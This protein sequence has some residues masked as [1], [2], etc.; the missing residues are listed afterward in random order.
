LGVISWSFGKDQTKGTKSPA[1]SN[2]KDSD[3]VISWQ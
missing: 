1:S 2:F 3:D